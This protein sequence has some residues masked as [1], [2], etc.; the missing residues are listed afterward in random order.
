MLDTNSSSWY[1]GMRLFRQKKSDDWKGVFDEIESELNLLVQK[2]GWKDENS[3][4]KGAYFL[5]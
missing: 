4:S 2:N 1:P 5:G 3:I